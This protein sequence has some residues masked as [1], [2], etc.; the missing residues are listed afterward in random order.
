MVVVTKP[1][2]TTP[3]L[4]LRAAAEVPIEQFVQREIPRVAAANDPYP[5]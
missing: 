5:G 2:A 4:L 3:G 1:V